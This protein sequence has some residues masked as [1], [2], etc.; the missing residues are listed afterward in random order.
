MLNDMMK[1]VLDPVCPPKIVPDPMRPNEFELV[2]Y[3]AS[4]DRESIGIPSINKRRPLS[5]DLL[6]P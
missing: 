2:Y 4:R 5:L 3:D 1:I 6:Y